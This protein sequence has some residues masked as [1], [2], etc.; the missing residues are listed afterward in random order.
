[1]ISQSLHRPLTDDSTLNGGDAASHVRFP[2]AD[3]VA[4]TS[5][6]SSGSGSKFG[7]YCIH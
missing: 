6:K 4:I 1:M 2:L 7:H 5:R 3:V